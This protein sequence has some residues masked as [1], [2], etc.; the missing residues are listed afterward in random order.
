MELGV[1]RDYVLGQHCG[2]VGG[3]RHTCLLVKN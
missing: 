1:Q 3:I 2:G